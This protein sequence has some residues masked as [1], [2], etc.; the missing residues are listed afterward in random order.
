MTD[1]EILEYVVNFDESVPFSDLMN[2]SYEAYHDDLRVTHEQIR[3]LIK[4][5]KL[6][7]T[8]EAFG[9]IHITPKGLDYL[10]Q[11]QYEMQ[12]QAQAESINKANQR[13]ENWIAFGITIGGG[14]FLILIEKLIDLFF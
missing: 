4:E 12:Q 5:K 1:Y 8:A 13:K 10:M 6:S 3:R 2:Y 14:I 9:T 7:G 11:T